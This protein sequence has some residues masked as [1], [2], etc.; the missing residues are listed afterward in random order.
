MAAL[1]WAKTKPMGDAASF[2]ARFK[3]RLPRIIAASGI[4]GASLWGAA[5]TLTPILYDSAWR[6]LG[7]LA[8]CAIGIV[9]YGVAG[10]ILG[11]F[12]MQD[13]RQALRR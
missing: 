8:L 9:V 7:L 12:K 13:F 2:D 11:A 5:S 4:M 10:Q 6:G 3:T 1:L